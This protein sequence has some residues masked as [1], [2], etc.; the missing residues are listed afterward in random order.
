MLGLDTLEL[1]GDLFTRDD[2][3]A[4][5][6]ITER[7][8]ADLAADAVLVADTQVLLTDELARPVSPGCFVFAHIART[9]PDS[10]RFG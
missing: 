1:D 5:V 6:D 2:V 8:R 10:K 9:M 4:E 7:A 3:S